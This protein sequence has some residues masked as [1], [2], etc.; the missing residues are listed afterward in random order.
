MMPEIIQSMNSVR[1]NNLSLEY[2]RFTPPVSKYIRIKK[3]EF[4]AKTELLCSNR[5]I[6]FFTF[7]QTFF[8]IKI[9][10]DDKIYIKKFVVLFEHTKHETIAYNNECTMQFKVE[11]SI[12]S[13]KSKLWRAS[14]FLLY[15]V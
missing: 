10:E 11:I 7:S 4:V 5:L 15:T 12:F 13:F 1:S 6:C 2:Q 3:F 14:I 9:T 8:Q